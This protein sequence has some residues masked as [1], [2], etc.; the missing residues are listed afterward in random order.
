V[1]AAMD[2]LGECL[3]DPRTA[4]AMLALAYEAA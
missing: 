4:Q 2:A 3:R 1:W